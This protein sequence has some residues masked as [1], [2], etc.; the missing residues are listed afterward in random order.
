MDLKT[1]KT[2]VAKLAKEYKRARKKQRGVLLDELIRLAQ[3]NRSYARRILRKLPQTKVQKHLRIKNSQ[4]GGIF[5]QLKSL[6]AIS[7]FACGKRLVPLISV[8]L[9]SLRRHGEL[10]VTASERKLLLKI[11]S[12]TVDRLLQV[13]KR[14]LSITGK[15]RSYTKPGSLLKHQ[16]PIHT[17][18]DWDNSKPG[19]LEI[20]TVHHNGGNP[21]GEYIHTLD[22]TDVATGWNECQALMGRGERFL[23]IAL[24]TIRIRLPFPLLGIDFD[25]GGEFVN[26]HLIRYSKKNQ[27][28]YTRA[29]ESYSNDQPYIEQQ[30]YSVVRTFVGYK[31]LDTW[32]QLELLNKLY[33]R[34]SGYQNFFQ[35][36]MRLKEKTRN[37]A[38]VTRKYSKA[39]TAYQ[40]VLES[41]DISDE[42]KESL[43]ER[44][45]KLNPKRLLLEINALA[46]K[47]NS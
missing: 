12:A 5:L 41:S 8:Y 26:Y 1:K 32:K 13:E 44:F 19:F 6:W 42:V 28:S 40:R 4:Y 15:G 38:H 35:S 21:S 16:I 3:Y 7:N 18:R 17:W 25:S 39:K 11:S 45:L 2:I 23:V 22:T 20:D 43:K 29:R 37:G 14:K 24:D 34:L 46:R 30:N 47:V 36:V 33:L 9:D 27:I 31:R 10:R